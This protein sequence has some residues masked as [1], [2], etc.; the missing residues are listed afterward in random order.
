MVYLKILL[1]VDQFDSDNNGTTIS[2]RRFAEEL[3]RHGNEVKTASIGKA[4]DRYEMREFKL[5]S[6]ADNIIKKQGM[7]FA[8][9][10]RE[11]LEQAIVW[12][13]VVH[14][15]MPFWLSLSGLKIAERLGVPR[16]FPCA[17]GK[18]HLYSGHG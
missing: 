12:A 13:D 17:A 8:R 18:Y 1:V 10:D 11:T 14:F 6:I 5:I 9:P 7:A 16:R 2:A 15:L 3:K 4:A